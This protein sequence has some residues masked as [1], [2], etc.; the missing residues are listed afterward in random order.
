MKRRAFLRSL[1]GAVAAA[2]MPFTKPLENP[3]LSDEAK[4]ELIGN[5]VGH[6]KW[7]STDPRFRQV[8]R[9]Y[10]EMYRKIKLSNPKA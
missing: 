8:D 10:A 7:W 3:Y 4:A 6:F 9:L 2:M 5:V 1:G